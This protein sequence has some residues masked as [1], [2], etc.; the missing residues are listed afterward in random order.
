MVSARLYWRSRLLPQWELADMKHSPLMPL[1]TLHDARGRIVF[2][3]PLL[4]HSPAE[5]MYSC[6][7][8]WVTTKQEADELLNAFQ[9]VVFDQESVVVRSYFEFRGE[10]HLYQC[11]AVP[12]DTDDVVA[13]ITSFPLEEEDSSTLTSREAECLRQLISGKPTIGIAQA[14]GEK[15]TTVNT[16]K[17]RLKQKLGVESL[18]G[19]IA[20]GCK[21]LQ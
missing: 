4:Y 20:W 10:R 13:M 19:L 2:A 16:Y 17:Q 8:D 5:I 21:H 6:P 1:I 3:E 11:R 14:M 12:V 7:W 9:Q 15:P 18:A